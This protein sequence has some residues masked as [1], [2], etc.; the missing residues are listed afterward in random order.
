MFVSASHVSNYRRSAGVLSC[1]LVLLSSLAMP[2]PIYGQT[3]GLSAAALAG[4]L[5][6][7][8]PGLGLA[9]WGAPESAA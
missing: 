4:G 8:G 9:S 1:A 6:P 2:S 3:G 7:A 5:V